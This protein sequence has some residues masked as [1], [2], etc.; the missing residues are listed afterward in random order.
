[1][2]SQF[3]LEIL[4]LATNESQF[5]KNLE[6]LVSIPSLGE[7]S[8]I[9]TLVE[10]ADINFFERSK[11]LAK[12]TG[13]TPRVNQSGFKKRQTGRLYKGGNKWL[14]KTIYYVASLDY[15]HLKKTG[16][17]GHPIGTFIRRLITQEKKPKKT[18][19]AAGARKLLSYVFHVL[20]QQRPFQEI[21]E[22]QQV[23]RLE[24]SR[25]RKLGALKRLIR[26]S[27]A[28]EILPIMVNELSVKT[29]ELNR[30][31]TLLANELATLLGVTPKIYIDPPNL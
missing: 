2:S 15:A 20:H 8:A 16:E 24:R 23:E 10:I 13:L 1:V 6:L 30:T 12:W 21:F 25:K 9:S 27:S 7:R 26:L 18:A 14:R 11:S 17:E 29:I 3:Y 22:L 19:I 4:H 5:Q 31:E 28:A